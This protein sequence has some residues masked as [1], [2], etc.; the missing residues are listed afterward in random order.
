MLLLRPL[1]ALS[2]SSEEVMVDRCKSLLF[3]L[4]GNLISLTVDW[5]QRERLEGHKHIFL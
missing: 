5:Q 3:L 2:M 4:G 1:L